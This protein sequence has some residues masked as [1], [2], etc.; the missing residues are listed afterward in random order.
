M[1]PTVVHPPRWK[2]LLLVLTCVFF[3][4]VCA[5][6]AGSDN[7]VLMVLGVAGMAAVGIAGGVVLWLAVRP[8]PTLRIDAE[9]ITDRTGVVPNGLVR[10]EE[11]AAIRKREIGR[12]RGAER[13]LD[14]V[15]VR[16]EEFRAR[17]RGPLR[18]VVDRY[19]RLMGHPYVSIPGSAVSV[20]LGTLIEQM[21]RWRPE[22]TVLELPP[23][24]PGLFRRRSRPE[25]RHR[26][27]R[28]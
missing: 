25:D 11:I 13:V 27:P 7:S 5:L 19:R 24:L 8:G 20:P 6:P 18:G 9:G 23:S 2:L 1:P 17:R 14:V 15:L 21:R 10:W 4:V 26:P 16:P 12:G 28:W 3:V 22:L